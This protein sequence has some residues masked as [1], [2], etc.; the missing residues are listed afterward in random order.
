MKVDGLDIANPLEIAQ[1]MNDYLRS[2]GKNLRDKIKHQP[3]PLLANE[4]TI[5]ENTTRF[6]FVAFDVVAAN[7]ALH[8]INNSF[9]IGSDGSASYFINIAF[10]IISQP[11]CDIFNFSI[12]ISMFPDKWKTA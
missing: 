11:P 7:K 10:P 9:G 4:Y 5:V 6:E 8:K 1:A 12:Y 3:D 2:V